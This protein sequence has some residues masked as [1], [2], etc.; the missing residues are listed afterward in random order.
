MDTDVS[1]AA[2]GGKGKQFSGL[3]IALLRSRGL[4]F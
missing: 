3:A 4:E 2:S 1:G